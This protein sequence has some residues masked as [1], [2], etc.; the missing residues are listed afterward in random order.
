MGGYSSPSTW[1]LGVELGFSDLVAG[2]LTTE[3]PLQS[4]CGTINI[5]FDLL[6]MMFIIKF[7]FIIIRLKFKEASGHVS[8]CH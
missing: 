7:K 6:Q 3:Q 4:H 1:I 2:V 8:A 5:T